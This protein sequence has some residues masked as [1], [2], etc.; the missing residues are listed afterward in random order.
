MGEL[1]TE[2]LNILTQ[3]RTHLEFQRALGVRHIEATPAEP[4]SDAGDKRAGPPVPRTN[5]VPK[6]LARQASGIQTAPAVPP[7]SAEPSGLEAIRLDLAAC[8]GCGLGRGRT[9]IVF[10][11]GNPHADIV[12]VG[13]AP[14]AKEEKQQRPFADAAGQLLT[15]II[16]KGMQLRREDMYIATAVKCRTPGDRTPDRDELEACAAFLGRQIDEIKPKIIVAL[17]AAAAHALLGKGLDIAALRGTWHEYHGIPVIPTLEP[18]HLIAHPE[19]KRF[20]WE[21][22]KKVL[23]RLKK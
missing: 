8:K 9:T 7:R 16:V 3:V 14:G 22:I 17:G 5:A 6:P 19:D 11:E 21:D 12:F 23:A 20:V 15:D 4:R 18:A 2:F 1:E 13:G 10:G